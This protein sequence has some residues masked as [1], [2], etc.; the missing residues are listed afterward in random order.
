MLR[1]TER[2]GME[3]RAH[4]FTS[5]SDRAPEALTEMD[6]DCTSPGRQEFLQNLYSDQD[7]F[8]VENT[9]YHAPPGTSSL[10][11]TNDLPVPC[12]YMD[13]DLFL[14]SESSI[15][16]Q[17]QFD[18]SPTPRQMSFTNATAP[19][20]PHSLTALLT[21]KTPSIVISRE[22]SLIWMSENNVVSPTPPDASRQ[23][24]QVKR[25]LASA[26][27]A[28]RKRGRPRKDCSSP[29]T[30]NPIPRRNS[31]GVKRVPHHEV[32]RKYREGLNAS[33][34]KLQRAVPAISQ[35]SDA[36]IGTARPSKAVVIDS[37]IEYIHRLEK[38][39]DKARFLL[40]RFN[41]CNSC[42]NET[43]PADIKAVMDP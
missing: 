24:R 41:K 9:S 31:D 7:W 23:T 19:V 16:S 25:A 15:E 30:F 13:S 27:I 10:W 20:E 36:I 32:E 38:E 22:S 1:A 40:D 34:R 3:D 28:S 18:F 4:S 37:A 29:E 11:L 21:E 12:N 39:R 2:S 26:P 8:T 35:L 14:A 42:I 43:G 17:S 5:R 33:F 6:M